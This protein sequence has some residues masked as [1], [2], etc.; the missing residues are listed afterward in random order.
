MITNID[1]LQ[2]KI[3]TSTTRKKHLME[4]EEDTILEHLIPENIK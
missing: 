1:G 2:K 3:T 4:M